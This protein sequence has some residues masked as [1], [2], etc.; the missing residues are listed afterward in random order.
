MPSPLPGR[1]LYL[2]L[3]TA[4]R[5]GLTIVH[6]PCPEVAA[7]YPQARRHRPPEPEPNASWPPAE[8][9]KREGEYAAFRGPRNQPP[10]IPSIDNLG[11]SRQIRVLDDEEVI[12][13]R[14]A[15]P[16]TLGG[17]P[18]PPSPLWG[19]CYQLVYHESRLRHPR[20][21]QAGLQYHPPARRHHGG[22]VF[23]TPSIPASLRKSLSGMPKCRSASPPRI[24][25]SSP[26]AHRDPFFRA[27]RGRDRAACSRDH[28]TKCIRRAVPGESRSGDSGLS[29]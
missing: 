19:I 2:S 21:G 10:G 1:P 9:R 28:S 5:I 7:Q 16:R 6:A 17:P 20:H 27:N 25:T 8:F 12:F 3:E 29:W 23:P 4:R 22:G 26:L 18:Y 24:G 15:A 11:M 13:Y 14:A